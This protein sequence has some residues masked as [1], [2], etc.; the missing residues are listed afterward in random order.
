MN[1]CNIEVP[2]DLNNQRIATLNQK[3]SM[4]R[5]FNN[6][7]NI[8]FEPAICSSCILAAQIMTSDKKNADNIKIYTK[9][10]LNELH[11]MD[12]LHKKLKNYNK[13]ISAWLNEC[14]NLNLPHCFLRDK[15]RN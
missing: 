14:N 8:K 1:M 13:K 3:E 9:L 4:L 5:N 2:D 7:K 10:Y 15:I 6:F 12:F 11:A